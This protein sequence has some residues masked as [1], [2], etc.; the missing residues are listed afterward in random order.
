MP[1]QNRV[2]PLNEIVSYPDHGL[3]MGNRGCLHDDNRKIV[4]HKCSVKRWII[5]LTSFKDRKRRLMSPEQYTELFFLD[6]VTALAAGHRPCAE[7]RR[8][9]YRLFKEAWI[10]GNPN[11][12]L[13][14]KSSIDNV[15]AQL[16]RERLTADGQQQTYRATLRELP[17]GTFF[18]IDECQGPL[19]RWKKSIF[20]WTQSGY[21]SV[22]AINNDSNVLVHTPQ[23]TVNAL[24]AGFIPVV[25]S[26]VES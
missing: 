1:L 20:L 23:S 19:L 13:T 10:N 12:G 8:G 21:E 3:F 11:S 22:S 2:T 25:H 14:D 7:C 16:H 18:T 15:D 17:S 26:S 5:C 24:L 9:D 6:E 4:R